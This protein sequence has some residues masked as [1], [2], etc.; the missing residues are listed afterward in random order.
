M[1]FANKCVNYF[2]VKSLDTFETTRRTAH[3][4]K[5][6]GGFMLLFHLFSPRS[7]F[8]SQLLLIELISFATFVTHP[9][10]EGSRDSN[11]GGVISL[12]LGQKHSLPDKRAHSESFD[13]THTHTCKTK[14]EPFVGKFAT[15]MA[16]LKD[17]SSP[18][19]QNWDPPRELS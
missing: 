1:K 14:D 12:N 11:P 15:N 5:E 6:L 18:T 2:L 3:A 10:R 19:T 9:A 16:N 13:D 17:F 8:L 7:L 4:S